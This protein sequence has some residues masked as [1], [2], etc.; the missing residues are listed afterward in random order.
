MRKGDNMILVS[1]CLCG[2]KCK[3]S[4]GDNYHEKVVAY[5]EGKQVLKVCPEVLGGLKTPRPPAEI[6]GGTAKEVFDGKARVMDCKGNDV[7]DAFIKGAHKVLSIAKEY[8]VTEAILKANSPS[9]GKG[10]VY[11][12]QFRGKRIEGNGLTAQQLLDAGIK[13]KTEDEM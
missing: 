6:V 9:C 12:G 3:Y 8:Q 13:V 5:C 1:S 11:D 10:M 4:G 2:E 7:T